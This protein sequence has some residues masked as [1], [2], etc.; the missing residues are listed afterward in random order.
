[1]PITE[2][3]ARRAAEKIGL[4]AFKSRWRADTTDNHGGFMLADPHTNTLVDGARF[5][6]SPEEI[7]DTCKALAA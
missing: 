7:V 6:Q 5:D 4:R 1:M 3:Q 2:S